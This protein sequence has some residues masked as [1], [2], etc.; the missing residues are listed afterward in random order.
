M[1]AQVV[2]NYLSLNITWNPEW[3]VASK[4]IGILQRA[5]TIY[6]G[7]S[8]RPTDAHFSYLCRR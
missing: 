4:W 1:D 7:V 3:D 5:C 6:Y 8:Y 2:L